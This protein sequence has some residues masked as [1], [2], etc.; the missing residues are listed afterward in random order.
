GALG[1]ALFALVA[2]RTWLVALPGLLYSTRG[3]LV[4]ASYTDL[5]AVRPGLHVSAVA[6]L[7]AAAMLVVASRRGPLVRGTLLA[8]GGFVAVSFVARSLV[9]GMV[10]RF[11]VVPT[12]L[13]RE[14]PSL[15]HHIELTR[16][17][18]GLD[19]V[20]RRELSGAAR[21]GLGDV[22]RNAATVEN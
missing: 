1:A 8:I 10:Q 13:T 5:H 17:A 14:A 18:W 16:R 20:E 11:V 9:P 4:G 12:E 2:A 6:A 15:R 21:I 22:R 3:P 19:R 7:A